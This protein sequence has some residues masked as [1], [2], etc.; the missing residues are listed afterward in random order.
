MIEVKLDPTMLKNSTAKLI[1]T[2]PKDYKN[3]KLKPKVLDLQARPVE[4]SLQLSKEMKKST[5]IK[6]LCE[7][8]WS[9]ATI[10]RPGGKDTAIGMKA[11]EV[12]SRTSLALNLS[13]GQ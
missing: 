3:S 5:P 2:N 4:S 12:L 13:D 7:G 10:E 8:G 11:R 1:A 9:V 6:Q